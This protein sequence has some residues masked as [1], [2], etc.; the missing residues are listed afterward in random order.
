MTA[1]EPEDLDVDRLNSDGAK[2]AVLDAKQSTYQKRREEGIC[3]RSASHGPAEPGLSLCA[4]CFVDKR[5]D[6]RER[7]RSRHPRQ[8]VITCMI[9]T[10]EGHNARTCTAPA[11]PGAERAQRRNERG[12][13]YRKSLKQRGFCVN[14]EAHSRPE[15]G[16]TLCENCLSKRRNG[17]P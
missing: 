5:F 10:R 7:Y 15:P 12:R 8:R 6:E 1:R 3:T 13:N 11:I 16:K 2:G 4:A 14:G 9:C 17:T